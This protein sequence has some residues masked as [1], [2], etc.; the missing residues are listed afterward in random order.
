MNIALLIYL[1]STYTI[2]FTEDIPAQD[3]LINIETY[4]IQNTKNI[5]DIQSIVSMSFLKAWVD[6][7]ERGWK[8][9][10]KGEGARKG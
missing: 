7:E 8:Y 3:L 5:L 2:H 9:L 6:F 4:T 10:K 1:A